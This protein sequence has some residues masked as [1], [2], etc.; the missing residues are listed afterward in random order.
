[1]FVEKASSSSSSSSSS[2]NSFNTDH[3]SQCLMVRKI[4]SHRDNYMIG[5]DNGLDKFDVTFRLS[6][7]NLFQTLVLSKHVSESDDTLVKWDEIEQIMT[8]Y[9]LV[10]KMYQGA[11]TENY[12]LNEKLQQ[13]EKSQQIVA[14]TE[15][16]C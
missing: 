9:K 14:H 5:I 12:K 11:M 6:T 4:I 10:M 13:A 8:D 3:E 16:H 2:N 1:M 7:E 15:A